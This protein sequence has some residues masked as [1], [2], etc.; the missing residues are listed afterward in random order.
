MPPGPLTAALLPL[1]Y[2]LTALAG[3]G[4]LAYPLHQAWHGAVSLRALVSRGALALVLL[5]LP[6][7]IVKLRLGRRELGLPHSAALWLPGLLGG[8]LA[9]VLI[10]ALLVL[11]ETALGLRIGIWPPGQFAGRLLEVSAKPLLV[12][13]LVG[14]AEEWLF[15]GV[16]LGALAKFRSPLYAIVVSAFY[17]AALH[18]Y[19]SSLKLPPEQLSWSSGF[20]IVGDGFVHLFQW[21]HLDSFAALYCAGLFLG[22]L[23]LLAGHGLA[24]CIGVHAG[25]VYTLRTSLALTDLAPASPWRFLVGNYDHIIGWLAAAWLALLALPL[26]WTLRRRV[27]T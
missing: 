21:N 14:S 5:G 20:V 18:F 2:L 10:M 12:G 7:L 4:L 15:R 27:P 1:S 11:L 24:L 26:L 3:A 9:G 23:R 22:C 25:W 8:L 19:H 13:L 17:Y 16:L 6:W